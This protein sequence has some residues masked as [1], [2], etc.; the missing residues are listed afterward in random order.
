V[1]LGLDFVPDLPARVFASVGD[2]RFGIGNPSAIDSSLAPDGCAAIT[3][4]CLLSEEEATP[5]FH[6]DPR[7]YLRSKNEFADRLIGGCETIIPGV[8]AGILYRQTA[9]P[10]TFARY[11]PW[12]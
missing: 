10:P 12:P 1:S 8:S 4:L 2:L 6:L 9:A 7:A 11:R 5:W 3:L